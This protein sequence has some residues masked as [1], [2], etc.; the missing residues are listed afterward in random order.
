MH[1]LSYKT[2]W[3]VSYVIINMPKVIDEMYSQ[4]N[5]KII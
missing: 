5:E 3:L 2:S 1:V 4:P